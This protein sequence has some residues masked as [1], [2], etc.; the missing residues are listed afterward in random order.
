MSSPS[1]QQQPSYGCSYSRNVMQGSVLIS[2]RRLGWLENTF[3]SQSLTG[4]IIHPSLGKLWIAFSQ[5][6]LRHRNVSDQNARGI[7]LVALIQGLSQV[8]AGAL[9]AP[10]DAHQ[11]GRL[12]LHHADHDEGEPRFVLFLMGVDDHKALAFGPEGPLMEDFWDNMRRYGL[13]ALTWVVRRRNERKRWVLWCGGELN[14]REERELTEGTEAQGGVKGTSRKDEN[15]KKWGELA[16]ERKDLFGP[17]LFL[18]YYTTEAWL[19]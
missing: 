4:S 16:S 17:L 1:S 7:S 14:E 12:R 19:Y 5:G 18:F 11:L 3:T 9:E 10:D 13:Y 8:R 6:L 2:E 15:K